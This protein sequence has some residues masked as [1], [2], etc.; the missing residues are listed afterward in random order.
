MSI[1]SKPR[2][3]TGAFGTAGAGATAKANCTPIRSSSGKTVGEVRQGT[4]FKHLRTSGFVRNPPGIS[5]ELQSLDQVERAGAV[6]VEITNQDTGIV[7]RATLE[8][9]RRKG[10][11][12]FGNQWMLALSHWKMGKPGDPEQLSFFGGAS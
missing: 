11:R 2:W 10:F 9:I 6:R 12:C 8:L 1:K 7:Y 3:A 4:F 5:F